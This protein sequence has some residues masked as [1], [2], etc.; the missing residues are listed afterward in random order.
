MLVRNLLALFSI[1][2]CNPSAEAAS[3]WGP[4][5][6]QALAAGLRAASESDLKS[7]TKA[8]W[9]VIRERSGLDT[10]RVRIATFKDID[11]VLSAA[12]QSGLGSLDLFTQREL[13]DPSAPA[14]L[15]DRST[16]GQIDAKFDLRGVWLISANTSS[17]DHRAV[18]MDY[19]IVGQGKLIIGYPLEVAVVV[20]EDGKPLEYRYEPF[21]EAD[22][23]N[24][25]IQQGLFNVKALNKPDPAAD[26]LPFMG[27]MGAEL[28]SFQVTGRSVQVQYRLGIERQTQAD[29]T[30]IALKGALATRSF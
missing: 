21:I 10:S 8:Y 12:L 24:T 18:P 13:A 6:Y 9:C 23:R 7:A 20:F 5:G 28:A 22:I 1:L 19:L 30:P 25:G 29:R 26:F 2:A 27:P 3:L 17:P 11:P 16:L 4:N 14:L 15:L